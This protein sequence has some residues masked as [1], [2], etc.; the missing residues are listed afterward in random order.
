MSK[1][2]VKTVNAPAPIGP[3]NQAIKANGFV[4]LSGQVAFDPATGALVQD[5]IAAETHQVMK[6]IEAVLKE[7]KLSFEHIVKTTIFLSDMTLFAEVNEV[8]G[9]YFNG[10]YPARET[11][12]VKGLPRGVNVEIS[13]TAVVDL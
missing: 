10:D 4:F 1:Q 7:A 3:Y 11:V 12:A 2:V 5:N 6:N 8:Y 13:M 9:T